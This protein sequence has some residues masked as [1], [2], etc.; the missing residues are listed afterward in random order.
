MR[1]RVA[2]FD[3]DL[4]ILEVCSIILKIKGYEIITQT[5][6]IDILNKVKS[7]KPDVILMDNWI[8]DIGGIKATQLLK[9]DDETKHIQVIF[10]SANNNIENLAKEATAD[11]FLQ[12]PFDI[13]TLHEMVANALESSEAAVAQK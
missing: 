12:K 6:C 8:P 7:S 13:S 3:D 4:D 2:I 1:K 5:N 9:A 10:F 11:Q